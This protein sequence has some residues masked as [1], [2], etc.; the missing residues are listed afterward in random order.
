MKIKS[1]HWQALHWGEKIPRKQKKAILGIRMS[2]CELR[3]L[4]K[5]V[6]VGEPI[7]TM[8]ETPD[9][10]PYIFCPNCGCGNEY[11]SG[12]KTSY[13]EHWEVFN[14]MR[15]HQATAYIDNSPYIHKLEYLGELTYWPY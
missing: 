14:C 1:K 10:Y 11:G 4:I 8:Y 6:K 12:N 7:K 5:T 9:I 2:G 3:R 15:C 13:P